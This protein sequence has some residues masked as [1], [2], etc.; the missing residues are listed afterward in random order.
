[1]GTNYYA[2][3]KN[4]SLDEAIHI[5]KSSMGWLFLFQEQNN[6][7]IPVEWHTYEEVKNW[8]YENTV[9]TDKYVILNEYEEKISFDKLM[10]IIQKKQNDRI[11]LSNPD[12]FKFSRNVNGYRFSNVTF[13]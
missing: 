1:M 7:E 10:N 8:L 5:G 4:V 6:K 2:V 11:C 13:S 3:R 12:N 9:K